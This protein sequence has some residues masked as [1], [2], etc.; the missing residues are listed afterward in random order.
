MSKSIKLVLFAAVFLGLTL[1]A[2][3]AMEL[4]AGGCGFASGSGNT[5]VVKDLPCRE[6]RCPSNSERTYGCGPFG[7]GTI[8][9][10]PENCN[11][12]KL[13]IHFDLWTN[14]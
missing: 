7:R 14:W 6:Y 10:T 3:A 1:S 9:S 2:Q 5:R 11:P 12:S 8:C 4:G 13:I